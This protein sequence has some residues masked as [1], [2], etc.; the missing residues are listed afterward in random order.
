[1]KMD[2][3]NLSPQE[4]LLVEHVLLLNR[5]VRTACQDAPY[6]HVLDASEQAIAAAVGVLPA[7]SPK[8]GWR[9]MNIALFSKRPAGKACKAEEWDKRTLPRPSACTAIESKPNFKER[10]KP[11]SVR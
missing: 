11:F 6:G 5:E 1:M 8:D 4:R 10:W 7:R 9:M 2:F 3:P